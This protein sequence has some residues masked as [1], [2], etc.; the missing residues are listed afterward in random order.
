MSGTKQ[1]GTKHKEKT[2][3]DLQLQASEYL[4]QILY[5]SDEWKR[6][7]PIHSIESH[8]EKL[9]LERILPR[10]E[11]IESCVQ[12]FPLDVYPQ[13]IGPTEC[14]TKGHFGFGALR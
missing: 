13:G 4:G 3:E 6:Q 7:Q 2:L 12:Q 10:L 14:R 1:C 5:H 9:L 11:L 8:I